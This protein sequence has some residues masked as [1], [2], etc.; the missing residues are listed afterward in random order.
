MNNYYSDSALRT[1][2][3]KTNGTLDFYEVHYD[4]AN[5]SKDSA[6]ANPLSHWGLDKPVVI[7]EFYALA[8]D[9]VTAD[10]MYSTLFTNGYGGAWAWQYLNADPMNTSNGGQSTKWP[11]MPVPMQNLYAAHMAALACP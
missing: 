6:F 10:D 9:G 2:G 3:G 8:Q 1:A 11:A 4:T 7:G 5:G